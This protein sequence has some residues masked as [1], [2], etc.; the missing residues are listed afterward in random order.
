MDL[1]DEGVLL[2]PVVEAERTDLWRGEAR[3]LSRRV[4]DDE[5]VLAGDGTRCDVLALGKSTD[6]VVFIGKPN[7][8]EARLR[9]GTSVPLDGGSLH[10]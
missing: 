6:T 5:M 2:E 3:M 9:L 8:P 4:G 1:T 10:S 7:L